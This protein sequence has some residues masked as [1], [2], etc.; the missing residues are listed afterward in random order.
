MVDKYDAIIWLNKGISDN[1][2]GAKLRQ[3]RSKMN[4]IEEELCPKVKGKQ[5]PKFGA[6]R[7]ETLYGLEIGNTPANVF[8]IFWW[9]WLVNENESQT[10]LS[11]I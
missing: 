10:L 8:P 5:L 9:R 3:A 2:T 6:G 11:R 1:Y 7:S 4:R